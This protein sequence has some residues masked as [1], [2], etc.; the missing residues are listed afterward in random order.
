KIVLARLLALRNDTDEYTDWD[1]TDALYAKLGM[2]EHWSYTY[3]FTG[4]EG[5]A[6]ALRAVAA[7]SPGNTELIERITKWI[8]AQRDENGWQNTKTTAEVFQALLEKELA[9]SGGKQP[10]FKATVSTGQQLLKSYAFS[11]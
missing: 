5:T 6:L 3:R 10:D 2:K 4:V 8:L 9:V 1:H 7:A 11:K